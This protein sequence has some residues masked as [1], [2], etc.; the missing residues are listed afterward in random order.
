MGSNNREITHHFRVVELCGNHYELE[1][2]GYGTA[3]D[4]P[5]TL[6][7]TILSD[8][9]VEVGNWAVV[10]EK[11]VCG[12][13]CIVKSWDRKSRHKTEVRSIITEVRQFKSDKLRVFD[14]HEN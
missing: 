3:V 5:M 4:M 6:D 1:S 13:Q 12:I 8:S 11:Y 9:V 14:V 2:Y 10:D 7:F